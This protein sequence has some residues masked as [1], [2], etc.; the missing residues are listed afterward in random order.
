MG[1]ASP[2]A[3]ARLTT[4]A[5]ESPPGL[6]A[7]PQFQSRPPTW[8]A[9]SRPHFLQEAPLSLSPKVS[10]DLHC[11]N[12]LGTTWATGIYRKILA[13]SVGLKGWPGQRGPRLALTAS[14]RARVLG[15][16]PDC[17]AI[18]R[19][20]AGADVALPAWG[21]PRPF[22]EEDATPPRASSARPLRVC[23]VQAWW[24]WRNPSSSS[25]RSLTWLGKAS[26]LPT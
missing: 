22:R 10:L 6:I 8:K 26:V 9:L 19:G 2:G 17:H 1:R 15:V 21:A 7:W 16:G 5:R 13:E 11:T 14:H 18:P 24:V 20:G 23:P 3:L 12:Q 25:A 4:F